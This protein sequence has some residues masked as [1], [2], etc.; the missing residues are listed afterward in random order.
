MDR[1]P[2]TL[3]KS[4]LLAHTRLP[5]FGASPI[6]SAQ[7]H[8]VTSSNTGVLQVVLP[9]ADGDASQSKSISSYQISLSDLIS[10]KPSAVRS[11]IQ[12]STDETPVQLS[13]PISEFVRTPN[14]RGLLSIGQDAEIGVWSKEQRGKPVRGRKGPKS[15]LGRGHWREKNRPELCTIYAKGR[16][17]VFYVKPPDGKPYISLQH[18]DHNASNPSPPTRLPEFELEDGD[19]IKMLSAASDIDD[20]YSTRDRRTQ[21][22]VII[23]VSAKGQAWIWRVDARK[24]TAV[25]EKQD[26][27]TSPGETDN[28]DI[29]LVSHSKI[30]CCAD[31]GGATPAHVLPVDPMGWHQ[32]VMDWANQSLLQD[33]VL[34]ISPAGVLEFW[35]PRIGDHVVNSRFTTHQMADNDGHGHTHNHSHDA[36]RWVRTG[37]VHTERTDIRAARCS[38]RKKT[39]LVRDVEGEKDKDRGKGKGKMQ[40][41]TIWDSNVGEFSTGLEMCKLYP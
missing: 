12:P 25:E 2:P 16:A 1:K 3:L 17:I 35:R 13:S 6:L 8:I 27:L 11:M 15:L 41:M 26:G 33:I 34:T 18:L 5:V 21:Q 31:E 28:P 14:G 38:S 36:E 37:T 19:E 30:P 23:A 7:P 4:S 32:S 29:R 39:V 24:D 9:A 20:G 40:E 10:S 22:A